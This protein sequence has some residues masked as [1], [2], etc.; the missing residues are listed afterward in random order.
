MLGRAPSDEALIVPVHNPQITAHISNWTGSFIL[1][2]RF[3][4]FLVS[5]F[6]VSMRLPDPAGSQ[7]DT[8]PSSGADRSAVVWCGPFRDAI[9]DKPKSRFLI[10]TRVQTVSAVMGE[11]DR[12]AASPDDG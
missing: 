3:V 2:L 11:I 12:W 7:P 6:L 4:V 5:M 1:V 9:Q 8:P 10:R